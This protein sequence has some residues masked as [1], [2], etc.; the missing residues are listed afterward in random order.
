MRAIRA[1]RVYVLVIV[2]LRG[3]TYLTIMVL[4]IVRI[5]GIVGQVGIP[6]V[7]LESLLSLVVIPGVVGLVAFEGLLGFSLLGTQRRPRQQI[8]ASASLATCERKSMSKNCGTVPS[9]RLG[10]GIN[11][12]AVSPG[13]GRTR[14]E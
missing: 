13:T 12:A 5:V 1:I 9:M 7:A 6:V 10:A 2:G 4:L 11:N 14:C 8:R 3:K